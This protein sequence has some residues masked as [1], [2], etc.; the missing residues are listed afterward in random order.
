MKLGYLVLTSLLASLGLG[1]AAAR[2][3]HWWIP[4]LAGAIVLLLGTARELRHRP[5]NRA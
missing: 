3:P 2:N 5:T 1:L 4:V